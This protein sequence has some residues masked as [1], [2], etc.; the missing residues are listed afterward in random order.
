MLDMLHDVFNPGG[1]HAEDERQRLEH[2]RV[3]EGDHG[4]GRGPIDLDCGL[5]VL[6]ALPP[7]IL[8]ARPRLE[9]GEEADEEESV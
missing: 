3:I 7:V 8:P 1:K 9:E 6:I 2:T 5:A 4:P